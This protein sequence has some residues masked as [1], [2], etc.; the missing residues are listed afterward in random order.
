ML[1]WSKRYAIG[2]PRLDA[3]HVTLV[4]LLNQLYINLA[5]EK[6]GDAIDPILAA[7]QQYAD[8]HFRFEESLMTEFGYPELEA[9]Q[10]SHDG[11]SIRIA[12]LR[13]EHHANGDVARSLRTLL[14]RWL[15]DHVV[16]VDGRLGKWLNANRI[17]VPGIPGL[18]STPS[19][20]N[21]RRPVLNAP[22]EFRAGRA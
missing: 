22:L 12:E 8:S 17:T 1:V 13:R 10:E 19:L 7:L 20:P 16:R 2:I 6:C 21:G 18:P 11:F 9:H 4:S 5:E 3:D 15:F 14:G